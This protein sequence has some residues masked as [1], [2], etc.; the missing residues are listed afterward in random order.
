MSPERKGGVMN[1]NITIGFGVVALVIYLLAFYLRGGLF[2]LDG[3]KSGLGTFLGI[4]PLLIFSMLIAGA[5]QTMIP[6]ELISKW[7]GAQAGFK[8]VCLGSLIGS[9]V[10][11]GPYGAFP[12][13]ASLLKSGAGLGTMVAFVAAWSLWGFTRLPLEV[14]IV[15]PRFTLIRMGATVVFPLIAG[16]GVQFISRLVSTT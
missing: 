5:V 4:L 2:A 13:A 6:K 9:I 15:G 7:L 8:G 10:P 16:A 14:A 3:I 1:L 11:G 12:V